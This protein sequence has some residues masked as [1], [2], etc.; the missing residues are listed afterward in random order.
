ME[1]IRRFRNPIIIGAG[2]LVAAIVVF[3]AVISPEGATLASLH[4]RQSQ[5]QSQQVR[6]QGEI[7]TLRREKAHLA[8]NCQVLTTDIAEIPGAPDVDSFL[9]QVTALAVASGDPNTPSISVTQAPTGGSSGVTAVAVAFTLSGAYGQMTSFL[10]G[11][12]AFPRLFTVSA[13]TI[14]GGPAAA[15]GGPVA[16]STPN[17]TLTLAGDIYYSI[18]REDV[19]SGGALAG[20]ATTTAAQ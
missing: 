16:P 1:N 2:A 9:N 10:Q 3:M 19:C 7:A 14:A 5:L 6:L 13:I 20:S 12:S 18:G 17:Y 8:A 15:G 11:L 4:A